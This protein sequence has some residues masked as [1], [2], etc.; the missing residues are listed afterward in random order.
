MTTPF[1][2]ARGTPAPGA[3]NADVRAARPTP[4]APGVLTNG[5]LSTPMELGEFMNELGA[6]MQLPR[7]T[8]TKAMPVIPEPAPAAARSRGGARRMLLPLLAVVLGGATLAQRLTHPTPL[9]DVPPALHGE[10][11]S[12]HAAYRDRRL[13]FN[14]T[15]LGIALQPFAEPTLHRVREVRTTARHDTTFVELLY[16]QE[17]VLVPFQLQ[18]T[19]QPRPRLVLRHPPDVIWEPVAASAGP[20]VATAVAPAAGGSPAPVLDSTSATGLTTQHDR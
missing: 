3:S 6:V 17:G 14:G 19:T 8:V 10:W 18:H 11:Q 9:A 13:S 2:P 1:P 20:A 15:H 16:E 7:R 5:D 4:I 12:T